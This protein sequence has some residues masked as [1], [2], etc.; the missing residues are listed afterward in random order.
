MVI[1]SGLPGLV[2]ALLLIIVVAIPVGG[3]AYAGNPKL[4]AARRAIR[5]VRYDDARGLLVEALDVG[6][7]AP[8]EVLEIYQLSAATAVVLGQGEL[9]ERYYRRVLALEPATRL[10]G[11]SSPKLRPPFVAAQAYMAAQGR[12]EARVAWRGRRIEVTLTGDP[13]GMVASVAA[14]SGGAA[15]T[16]VAGDTAVTAVAGGA[17]QPAVPVT[18]ATIALEPRG[19]VERILLLDEHGNA[20]RELAVP[21][22]APAPAPA[23]A[24]VPASAVSDRPQ[25]ISVFRR[26]TT[27][28]IPAAV[29]AGTGIGFAI[30]AQRA[31]DRL[32][33]ILG[34]GSSHF[35][36]EA[37]DQR[38]RWQTDAQIAD[39][40]LVAAGALTAAAIATAIFRPD[41]STTA[42]SATVA[43]GQLS[44]AW[45]SR[46]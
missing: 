45:R 31:K 18:G 24:V 33:D 23:P 44:V 5:D 17:V 40:L 29:L 8:D 12:L 20:L 11:D 9:A 1:R 35:F 36:D 37:E 32:D 16:A 42:I 19:S 13:L 41:P 15:A 14:V 43:P 27:W 39:V 7:N 21:A 30:S 3:V 6:G 22:A 4:A 46:F 38:K 26:W 34:D 10:P 2:L 25:P 28:A